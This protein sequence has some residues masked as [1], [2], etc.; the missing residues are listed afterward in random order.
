MREGAYSQNQITSIIYMIAV[1]IF[2][3][4]Y[5]A[6]STYNVTSKIHKF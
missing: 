6:D 2:F 3:T 4:P 5:F 1:H